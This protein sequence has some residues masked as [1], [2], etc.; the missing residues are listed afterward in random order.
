M[1]KA[2]FKPMPKL[3]AWATGLI[4]LNIV[5]TAINLLA[6]GVYSLWGDGGLNYPVLITM[7]LSFTGLFLTVVLSGIVAL[8]WTYGAARNAK[9]LRPAFEYTPA[10]A[11]GW[12]FVPFANL[13]KPYEVVRDIF[14]ASRG[15]VNGRY[16]KGNRAIAMW[17]IFNIVGN[18]G[19]TVADRMGAFRGLETEDLFY[20]GTVEWVWVGFVFIGLVSTALFLKTLRTIYHDQTNH[21]IDAVEVF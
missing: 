13:Y 7:A 11:V 20:I 10:W 3:T 15:K 9:A 6:I 21:K 4:G 17:W 12:Y 5:V 2:V 16:E 8:M 14:I 18:I 1:K 19:S